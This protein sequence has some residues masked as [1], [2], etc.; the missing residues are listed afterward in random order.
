MESH[1]GIGSMIQIKAQ[2][3]QNVIVSGCP[4][5]SPFIHVYKQ[6]FDFSRYVKAVRVPE[7]DYGKTFIYNLDPSEHG[8]LLKEVY[9]TCRF[10][11]LSGG[12]D[13]WYT[14]SIG[15]ALFSKIEL[16]IGELVI[17]TI[18]SEMLDIYDNINL[19]DSKYAAMN[20]MVKRGFAPGTLTSPGSNKLF[21]HVPLR[22]FFSNSTT[23]SLPL[24]ALSHQSIQ[25]KFFIREEWEL[26]NTLASYGNKWGVSSSREIIEPELWFTEYTIDDNLRDFFINNPL[27][28]LIKTMK[29]TPPITFEDSPTN[30]SNI[31]NFKYYPDTNATVSMFTWALRSNVAT[32]AN[33]VIGTGNDYFGYSNTTINTGM[34]MND[35][36]VDELKIGDREYWRYLQPQMYLEA[37]PRREINT[38]SLGL[39]HRAGISQEW[40]NIDFSRIKGDQFFFEFNTSEINLE[41]LMYMHITNYMKINNGVIQSYFIY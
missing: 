39:K 1:S 35:R 31:T 4:S 6:Y 3:P 2:G 24:C 7:V 17:D 10:P 14:D 12:G 16:R 26:I 18:T 13:M 34:F 19:T 11:T 9:F 29:I 22:F 27:E 21:I 38:W 5:M 37:N 20:W 28:Y 30:F 33:T 8:D 25:I 40:G 36:W 32:S 23:D 41:L 15:Q